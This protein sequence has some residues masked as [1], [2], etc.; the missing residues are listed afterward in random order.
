[1]SLKMMMPYEEMITS[2][3]VFEWQPEMGEVFFLSH[4]WTSFSHPDPEA[5]QLE[6]AQGFLSKVGEG[7]I[8]SLFATQEE[9]LAF[10]YKES[11]RFLNFDVVDEEQIAADVNEGYVWLDYASVPQAA[12]AAAEE[13]RLRAID[14]IPFYVDHALCFLAIVPKV[15]HKDLKGTYC[16]YKS[17]SVEGDRLD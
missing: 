8:K 1:M 12:D 15:E 17:W 2:G 6:V 11:N 16:T 4:Q 10:H 3:D 7:K 13:Q 14:S 9:W 5:E